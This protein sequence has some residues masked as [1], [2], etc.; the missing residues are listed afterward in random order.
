[1]KLRRFV[2][3]AL[4]LLAIPASAF[5]Q[6]ITGKWASSVATPQG[7]FELVFDLVATGMELTGTM[8]NAMMGAIPVIEG[9]VHEGE[10]SFKIAMQ[11][12]DGSAMTISYKG[13]VDGD[14]L[15]MIS[16][17]EGAPPGGGPAEQ[18]MTATRVK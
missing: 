10:V 13:T 18:P 9:M 1:M 2:P 11:G 4:T 3:L 15:N 5:A 8:S 16:S 17:F 12:P 14:T 7:P 6:D